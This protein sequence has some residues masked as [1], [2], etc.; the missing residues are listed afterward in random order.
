MLLRNIKFQLSTLYFILGFASKISKRTILAFTD[1]PLENS[2]SS[3][4]V[5]II[6]K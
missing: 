6:Q 4:F 2:E 3:K 5:N 1:T